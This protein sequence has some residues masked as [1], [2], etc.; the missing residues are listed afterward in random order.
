MKSI[1]IDRILKYY[2]YYLKFYKVSGNHDILIE[3]LKCY[4]VSETGIDCIKC[5]MHNRWQRGDINTTGGN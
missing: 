4:E 1:Y 3:V 5:Y 2:E